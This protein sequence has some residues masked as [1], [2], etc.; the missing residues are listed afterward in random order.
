MA[1]PITMVS[2]RDHKVFLLFPGGCTAL[3][4]VEDLARLGKGRKQ[5]TVSSEGGEMLGRG[6]EVGC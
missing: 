1:Q 6:L 3:R 4:L 5:G 2:G